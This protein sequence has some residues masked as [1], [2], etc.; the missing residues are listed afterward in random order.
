M[1]QCSNGEFQKMAAMQLN[2]LDT[3]KP[4]RRRTLLELSW[5][6]V[7]AL[8]QVKGSQVITIHDPVVCIL[9]HG[10]F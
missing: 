9:K 6:D 5:H 8:P 10:A 2:M 3:I 1:I 4:Q 7:T